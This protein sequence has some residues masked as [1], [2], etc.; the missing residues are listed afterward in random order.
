MW[1]LIFTFTPITPQIII[2]VI[3]KILLYTINNVKHILALTSHFL[4]LLRRHWAHCAA[5]TNFQNQRHH[6]GLLSEP[7]EEGLDILMYVLTPMMYKPPSPV[8]M[9]RIL[10]FATVVHSRQLFWNLWKRDDGGEKAHI[11]DV[12]TVLWQG[13]YCWNAIQLVVF[14]RLKTSLTS[15]LLSASFFMC[16]GKVL[17]FSCT[18]FL[19]ATIGNLQRSVLAT[20]F[21]PLFQNLLLHKRSG[22]KTGTCTLPNIPKDLTAL[23]RLPSLPAVGSETQLKQ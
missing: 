19:M 22:F 5:K 21:N 9:V 10:C 11:L 4:I 3:I 7:W 13:G 20:P 8:C 6:Q 16:L 18:L 23:P 2:S 12:K 14:P 1:C 17:D 15:F